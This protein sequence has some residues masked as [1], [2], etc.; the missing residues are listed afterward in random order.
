[1]IEVLER[2]AK[3]DDDRW[4]CA[5]AIKVIQSCFPDQFIDLFYKSFF[6]KF[7]DEEIALDTDDLNCKV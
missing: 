4:E 3:V 1:M 7:I 2:I 6:E 5:G